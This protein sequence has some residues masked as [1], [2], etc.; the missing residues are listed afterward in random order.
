[1]NAITKPYQSHDGLASSVSDSRKKWARLAIPERLDGKRVLDIGCNEGLFSHWC[2]ERGAKEVIGIDRHGPSLAFARQRYGSDRVRFLEQSWDVL[3]EGPFDLVL[4]ISA[5]HYEP[6]PIGVLDRI[7]GILAPDG[8]L[9]LECGVVQ[10]PGRSMVLRARHDGEHLYPT[11]ELLERR[12]LRSFAPRLVARP[13][14]TPGD[15]VPRSVYHCRRRPVRVAFVLGGTGK[16]KTDFVKRHLADTATQ[17]IS[18][19]VVLSRMATEAHHLHRL[20]ARV[21]EVYD[22]ANLGP[23]YKVVNEELAEPFVDWLGRM[24]SAGDELVV[25]EGHLAD[26]V[27]ELFARRH[28]GFEVWTVRRS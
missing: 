18:L 19:D 26:T 3:P 12:L 5:M 27:V 14:L 24:V 15:P 10:Q 7:A 21:R 17:T 25:F 22:P 9:V 4:W 20:A 16:G 6:N 28:P 23:V 11:V 13:E 8:I 2:A 1:M